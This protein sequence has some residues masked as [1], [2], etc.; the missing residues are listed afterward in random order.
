[1]NLSIEQI[2]KIK[3]NVLQHE[4]FQTTVSSTDL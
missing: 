3:D 2:P 4:T 1:M